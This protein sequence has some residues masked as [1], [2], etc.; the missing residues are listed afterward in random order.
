MVI[1]PF[2]YILLHRVESRIKGDGVKL[3]DL[4]SDVIGQLPDKKQ[5]AV[6]ELVEEFGAG[7]TFRFLL[8]LVAA[9]STRERR[10]VRLLL[11]ELEKIEREES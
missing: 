10:L 6:D 2:S 3:A 1:K 5:Q 4:L 8:A 7:E 9:T 11:R